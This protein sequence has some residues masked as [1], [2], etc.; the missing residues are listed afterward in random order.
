[1][2]GTLAPAQLNIKS[3]SA[4]FMEML[5]SVE[6]Y[7]KRGEQPVP[8]LR[9]I[10]LVFCRGESWGINGASP[11][12]IRLLLEI[13]A[14][15]RPYDSGR[16][17]LVCKGMMR[18]KRVILPHVFYI[19][20]PSMIYDN[21]NVLEFL[22]FATAKQKENAVD[23]QDR[24][25]EQLIDMGLGRISLTTVRYLS[26][27]EKAVVILLAAALSDSQ[28]VV[29]NLPHFQFDEVLRNAIDKIATFIL[30]RN[31]TLVLGTRDGDLIDKV[32]SHTAFLLNGRIAYAGSVWQFRQTY[33]QIVLTI[34]DHNLNALADRLK[35][36]LP[37]YHYAIEDAALVVSHGDQAGDHV[38]QLYNTI[39]NEGFHPA[40]IIVN[41]TTSNHAAKA[42]M[43]DMNHDLSE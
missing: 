22:M 30:Q 4:V 27:E 19:G 32:C 2:D 8:V 15:I 29:F 9:S 21:M 6:R 1:M 37:Q 13:I 11:F 36:V 12:E 40:K 17:V 38:E 20:S 26:R 35:K 16:C 18:R 5:G 23:R 33:D 25:F 42:L 24:I 39:V 43:K 28:L 7:H 41:P 34:W 3:D 10:N 14:N 31:A